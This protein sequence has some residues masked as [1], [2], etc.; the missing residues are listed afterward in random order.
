[1][2][3]EKRIIYQL[4]SEFPRAMADPPLLPNLAARLQTLIDSLKT[5]HNITVTTAVIGPPATTSQIREARKAARGYL[6]VGLE[7]FYSHVGFFRLEWR[8]TGPQILPHGYD[9]M[10]DWEKNMY[11]GD[12][13]SASVDIIPI[14]EIFGGWKDVLWFPGDR[15]QDE[16]DEEDEY[17]P[18]D[19]SFEEGVK[20]TNGKEEEEE[21]EEE[22]RYTY[23][24]LKPID[25]FVPEAYTVLVGPKKKDKKG[26]FSDYVAYHYCGEELFHTRYTFAEY[27]ERMIVARGWWYWVTTLCGDRERF[28]AD[29]FKKLAVQIFEDID[30]ALFVP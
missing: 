6:P 26:K 28:E 1:M 25:T 29:S 9:E 15:D 27:V 13:P 20:A 30:L 10:P 4:N 22:W 14:T 16:E 21:E 18:N 2:Q 5:K 19:P 3:K 8:Y 17:D 12:I 23:Q 24:H 7:E 11:K